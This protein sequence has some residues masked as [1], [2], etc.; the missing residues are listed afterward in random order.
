MGPLIPDSGRAVG[1]TFKAITLATAIEN[2]Y[3]PKDTVNGGAPCTIKYAEGTPGQ[4]DYYPWWNVDEDGPD[5]HKF[6]NASG[7]GGGTADL[8]SQTKNSVNCAFLRLLTSVGPPKV[9]E[10]ANRLGTHPARSAATSRSASAR[11]QH[12]PLEMATVYSTFADDGVRHDPVF[13]TRIED[14]EGRVIYRAPGGKRVLD[15]QVARTV[16]DVLSHVTEGTAPKAKLADRP[17]AGKTGTRDNSDD[18]WF[19]GLHAAA[20]RG[21]L[22]GRP[23]ELAARHDERGRDPGLRRDV[24][25]DHVAEV[26]D[27]GAQR[28][29]RSSRSRQPDETL[30][31]VVDPRQPRRWS[32]R[33]GRSGFRELSPATSSTAPSGDRPR[34]PPS[35]RRP[36]RRPPDTTTPDRAAATVIRRPGRGGGAAPDG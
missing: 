14:S 1:S 33:D 19:A 36:R 29:S 34:R 13:I 17:I 4:P 24:P 11:P 21:R 22:D 2:G 5:G 7:E 30:W 23:G 8:F 12:S 25:G 16:T 20:G 18:A 3:S 35:R 15:P 6:T 27:L 10:M 9:R 26:H 28:A 31:P 32:R